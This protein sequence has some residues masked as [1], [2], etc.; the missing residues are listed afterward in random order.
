MVRRKSRR[1][2]RRKSSFL[3]K[4]KSTRRRRRKSVFRKKRRKSVFRKK[5]TK[6]RRKSRK[7]RK[8]RRKVQKGGVVLGS[9]K[10]PFV[11]A[12]KV[13]G[14]SGGNYHALNGGER[15]VGSELTRQGAGYRPMSGGGSIFR[16]L[17]LT[18]PKDLYNDSMDFLNN[19]KNS[20]VGDRQGSTSDVTKQNLQ[21]KIVQRDLP[22]YW[23]N[24]S[25]ANADAASKISTA[26]SG[27]R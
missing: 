9:C 24:Y 6:N 23:S 16:N 12:A 19:V 14:A 18:F 10:N 26:T 11:G 17:G 8:R 20:Y 2:K 1:S 3:L 22:D 13:N 25:K 7:V 15:L 21:S 4:K 5:R 27:S